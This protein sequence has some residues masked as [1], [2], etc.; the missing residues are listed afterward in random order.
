MRKGLFLLGGICLLSSA[1]AAQT[2]QTPPTSKPQEPAT[3]PP[4]AAN[5]DKKEVKVP[6]KV[7]ATYVGEYELRSDW[8]LTV[9]LEEGSL[10]GQP[11]NQQKRQIFAESETKFYLKDLPVTF[12]FLKDDKGTV[13]AVHMIQEGRGERD[14]KKIK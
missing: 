4:A 2:P 13:T 1:L 3:K 10:W 11:T 5:Q 14:L 6:E 12:E 8:I 9:T 7:L